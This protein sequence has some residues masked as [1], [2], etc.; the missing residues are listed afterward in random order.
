MPTTEERKAGIARKIKGLEAQIE[1]L[2][3]ARDNLKET[4]GT[5][6]GEGEETVGDNENGWL[7]VTSYLGKKYDEAY[8]KRNAP[9][10]WE[11]HAVE[12][13]VL[14]SATAKAKLTEEEYARFQKPNSKRTVKVEVINND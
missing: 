8:G 10:L 13:R 6:V 3:E 9:E 12:V 2:E 14:P 1:E 7:K 11:K 5:L 4:L